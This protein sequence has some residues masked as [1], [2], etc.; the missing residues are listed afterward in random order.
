M[1]GNAASATC[2]QKRVGICQFAAER[3]EPS[4]RTVPRVDGDVEQV[5]EGRASLSKFGAYCQHT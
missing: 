4:V 5:D 1:E 3:A 2:T